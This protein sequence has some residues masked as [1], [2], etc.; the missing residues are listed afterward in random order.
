MDLFLLRHAIA[1]EHGAPGYAR[2]SDRVLTPKGSRKMRRVAGGMLAMELAFDVILTSPFARARQTADIVAEVLN[3]QKI[4]H[5]TKALAVGGNPEALI[6][7]INKDYPA[8]CGILLV[9]HEPYLSGLISI[10]LT[11]EQGLALTMKKGGL[12]KLKVDKLR[13]S[14]CAIL[15]WLLTPAQMALMH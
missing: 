5:Q 1:V 11:G 15:E 13:Y 9:G 2:D 10:L 14:E 8:A 3:A 6:E 12:C 7:R 4:V